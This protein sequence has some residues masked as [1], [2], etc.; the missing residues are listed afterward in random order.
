MLKKIKNYLYIVLISGCFFSNVTQ[1][2]GVG[3]EPNI[4]STGGNFTIG[5]SLDYCLPGSSKWDVT[6]QSLQ[7]IRVTVVDGNGDRVPGTRSFDFLTKEA[8]QPTYSSSQSCVLREGVLNESTSNWNKCMFVGSTVIDKD[9]GLYK[10]FLSNASNGLQMGI[11]HYYYQNS[12]G[13][14]RGGSS[15][16]DSDGNIT[17]APYEASLGGVISSNNYNIPRFNDDSGNV[18]AGSDSN[19]LET[20]LKNNQEKIKQMVRETGYTCL[21]EGCD[22]DFRNDMIIIEPALLMIY[23]SSYYYGTAR[24]LK[25][26]KDA[27]GIHHENGVDDDILNNVLKS[28]IPFKA[29]QVVDS[30]TDASDYS[31]NEYA[32]A[33][34]IFKIA[35]YIEKSSCDVELD[36]IMDSYV[37][38]EIDAGT[39]ASKLKNLYSKIKNKDILCPNSTEKGCYNVVLGKNTVEDIVTAL[40]EG[41][42][43]SCEPFHEDEIVKEETGPLNCESEKQEKVLKLKKVKV[44][45][46]DGRNFKFTCTATLDVEFHKPM[47]LVRPGTILKW[48]IGDTNKFSQNTITL[49]CEYSG[50]IRPQYRDNFENLSFG[51]IK[52]AVYSAIN[53][54]K[55]NKYTLYSY[56]QKPEESSKQELFVGDDADFELTDESYSCS[57]YWTSTGRLRYKCKG[58]FTAV[59]DYN[60]VYPEDD[61]WMFSKE[62]LGLAKLYSKVFDSEY[63]NINDWIRSDIYGLPTSISQNKSDYEYHAALEYDIKITGAKDGIEGIVT[64]PYKVK[65][66]TVIGDPGSV[67]FD[68]NVVFRVIDTE[69]PFPGLAGI[70]RETGLNWCYGNIKD[71][72]GVDTER[73]DC[74]FDNPVVLENILNR[75]NSYNV[76]NEEPMYSFVLTPENLREIKE[77]NIEHPNDD[78]TLE[79]NAGEECS[80]EFISD[81]VEGT[82]DFDVEVSGRCVE[83]REGANW[84][85]ACD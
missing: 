53:L 16:A 55:N 37:S 14:K 60:M 2:L 83:D 10:F 63:T 5:C 50:K 58:E 69:D 84:F 81:L 76:E 12:S 46:N 28:T 33:M 44:T 6:K 78:Y 11:N 42:V 61:M 47:S 65:T 49:Q 25:R 48:N 32:V 59:V 67:N 19:S 36:K 79:C 62:Q 24:D 52:G 73:G 57:E 45:V 34:G 22:R 18:I 20:Y 56:E 74:S 27:W 82:G 7:A 51:K 9:S 30:S 21:D 1:V 66:L 64:C 80:S 35:D 38:E 54:E 3:L 26:V 15:V 17:F 43:P 40:K 71:E 77:Y 29:L 41:D 13:Q 72:A 23:N 4:G 75:N 68:D 8:F 85:Q 70:G 39:Y 31:V